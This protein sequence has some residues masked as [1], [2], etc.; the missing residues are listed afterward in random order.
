MRAVA[1]VPEDRLLAFSVVN[2]DPLPVNVD[3]PMST[4]PKPDVTLPASS[5]PVPVMSV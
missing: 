1:N 2:P 3:A 4:F 5:A